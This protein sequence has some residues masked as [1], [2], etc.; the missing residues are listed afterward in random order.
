MWVTHI[1]SKLARAFVIALACGML[2][3]AWLACGGALVAEGSVLAD[4]GSLS[5]AGAKSDAV[6]VRYPIVYKLNEGTQANGQ[7]KAIAS[8]PSAWS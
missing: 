2:V 6:S 1:T 8:T 5:T 7:R 4:G 3:C